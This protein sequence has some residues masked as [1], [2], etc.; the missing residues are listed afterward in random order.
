M[1]VLILIADLV[2]AF[3]RPHVP[4]TRESALWVS[5][6]VGLALIFALLM[7][8]LG[9]AEHAGQFIAGW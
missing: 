1:I 5:F 9:D 6:Y 2:I 3:R 8:L 7:L 4:S